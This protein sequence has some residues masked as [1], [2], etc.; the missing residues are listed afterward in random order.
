MEIRSETDW[1]DLPSGKKIKGLTDKNM[2][3]KVSREFVRFLMR[4][5]KPFPVSVTVADGSFIFS[6]SL[7][8]AK[9]AIANLRISSAIERV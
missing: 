9:G 7:K 8:S 5:R 3:V 2:A 1:I 4:R 6:A